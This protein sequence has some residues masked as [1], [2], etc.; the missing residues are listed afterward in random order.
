MATINNT[1]NGIA[2]NKLSVVRSEYEADGVAIADVIQMITVPSGFRVYSV[3]LYFDALGA[4]STLAVGDGGDADRFIEAT[5]SV[6][7][8]TASWTPAVTDVGYMYTTTSDLDGTST[9]P[10]EDTIDVTVAGGAV[11]GTII[12]VATMGPDYS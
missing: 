2:L 5:S 1:N 7:A 4:D 3:D 11:T 8:G 10:T 9:V 12:V 6:S